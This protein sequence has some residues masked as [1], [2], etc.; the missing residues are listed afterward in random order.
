MIITFI[1]NNYSKFHLLSYVWIVAY[2][3]TP[4]ATPGV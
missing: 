2:D 1:I 3:D 4:N